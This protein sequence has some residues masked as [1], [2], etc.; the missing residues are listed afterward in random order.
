MK[1]ISEVKA[2]AQ[3]SSSVKI[4]K[5]LVISIVLTFILL[6]IFAVVLTYSNISENTVE[7]VI[8]AITGVSILVRKFYNNNFNKEKWDFKWWNNWIRIYD[9]NI[10][11][12]KYIK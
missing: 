7:P 11:S 4:L 3:N 1:E 5:G 6:F 10:F 2:M 9:T 8:I 12:I